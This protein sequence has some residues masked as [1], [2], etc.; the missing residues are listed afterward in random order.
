MTLL[1]DIGTEMDRTFTSLGLTD[2]RIR[3]AGAEILPTPIISDHGATSYNE[4]SSPLTPSEQ[5]QTYRVSI[6]AQTLADILSKALAVKLAQ[7]GVL[8]SP[9]LQQQ[10]RRV[11]DPVVAT[12]NNAQWEI[13]TPEYAS[14]QPFKVYGD[15]DL[16]GECWHLT[17]TALG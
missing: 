8:D 11:F 10:W 9:T 13:L 7:P 5:L 4:L 12:S 1:Q 16:H 14:W 15:S 17:L 2:R 6:P 3:Y